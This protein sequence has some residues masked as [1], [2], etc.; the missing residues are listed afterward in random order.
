MFLLNSGFTSNHITRDNTAQIQ[1]WQ[2]G[3]EI[4][5]ITDTPTVL[6]D[7]TIH[8]SVNSYSSGLAPA[9]LTLYV[10][11]MAISKTRLGQTLD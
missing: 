5:N 10:D 9:P 11:D 1:I 2:D 3:I 4:F 7:N 6:S 8:W